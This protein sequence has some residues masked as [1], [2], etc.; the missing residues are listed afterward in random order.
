[1]SARAEQRAFRGDSRW[2]ERQPVIKIRRRS[3]FSLGIIV[4]QER[5]YVI[6][7][8]GSVLKGKRGNVLIQNKCTVI[9]QL[10]SQLVLRFLSHLDTKNAKDNEEGATDEDDVA[11]GLEGRDERLHHQLQTWS[12]ADHPEEEGGCRLTE[13]DECDLKREIPLLGRHLRGRSVLSS[14]RTLSTPRIL[15]P[16]AMDTTMSIRDT[17]TRKP[18]RMFQL[19][20]R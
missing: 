7:M 3:K 17:K 1:M 10:V 14:R 6:K 16:P 2:Y 18:S 8:T 4:V 19:L 15:A 12:S 11:D 13:A 9:K 20:R 5:L